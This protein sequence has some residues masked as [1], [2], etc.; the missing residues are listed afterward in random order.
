MTTVCEADGKGPVTTG[1]GEAD[2]KG[3][4]GSGLGVAEGTADDRLELDA[5]VKFVLD[6]PACWAATIPAVTPM[7]RTPA[8]DSAGTIHVLLDR[9]RVVT[10]ISSAD[11]SLSGAGTACLSSPASSRSSSLMSSRLQP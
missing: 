8:A 10:M 1:V 5:G 2:G 7:I 11:S 9:S 3:P 6:A 4:V